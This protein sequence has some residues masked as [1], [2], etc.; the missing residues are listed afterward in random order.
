MSSDIAEFHK[1]LR[2]STAH[3]LG[4]DDAN[5]LTAAQEIRVDRAVMLR[6]MI[7][8]LQAKQMRGGP[9]DVRAFVT[10]SEDLERMVGGHPEQTST[11]PNFSGARDELERFLVARAQRIE[12][13]DQNR[14]TALRDEIARLTEENE[15][16]KAELRARPRAPETNNVVPIRDAN[17]ALPPAHYLRDGQ[18]REDW[19]RGPTFDVPSWPLPR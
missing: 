15:K 19:Q 12:A 10:A 13:R 3:L 2:A 9:I 8:D 5:P 16:L 7:D 1:H 4:Y 6:L 11:A 14:E 18:R 17:A